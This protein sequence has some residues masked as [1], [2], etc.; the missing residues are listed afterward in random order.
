MFPGSPFSLNERSVRHS[1]TQVDACQWQGVRLLR[2]PIFISYVKTYLLGRRFNLGH[3]IQVMRL[4]RQRRQVYPK[5]LPF[6]ELR[7]SS[8]ACV[9]SRKPLHQ[10]TAR[11]ACLGVPHSV[12]STIQRSADR[13]RRRLAYVPCPSAYK[14]SSCGTHLLHSP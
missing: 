5:H 1:R 14:T 6:F 11:T 8:S 12:F 4:R 2:R 10:T 7:A 3:D 13:Y 9:A